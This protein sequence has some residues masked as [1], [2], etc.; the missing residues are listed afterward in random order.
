MT[1]VLDIS[2]LGSETITLFQN[3]GKQRPS[4]T[5]LHFRADTDTDTDTDNDTADHLL[6]LYTNTVQHFP[7]THDKNNYIR[8]RI[9]DGLATI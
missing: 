1:F 9:G 3:V 7:T 4:K 5:A 2:I 6:N 8:C